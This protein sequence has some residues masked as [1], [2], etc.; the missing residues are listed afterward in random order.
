VRTAY[1]YSPRRV[2]PSLHERLLVILIDRLISLRFL[3]LPV[4][5]FKTSEFPN[6]VIDVLFHQSI[7]GDLEKSANRLATDK[8]GHSPEIHF[9][10]TEENCLTLTPVKSYVPKAP[11]RARAT[12]REMTILAFIS[13]TN[14]MCPF[15][16]RVDMREEA[17][18]V[19]GIICI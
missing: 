16:Q 2:S 5:P 6:S 13:S 3:L 15:L 18:S 12:N 17:V 7:P 19:V 9:A 14:G 1:F 8:M 10:S 11:P 4:G